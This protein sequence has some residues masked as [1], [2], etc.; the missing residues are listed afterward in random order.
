M[1]KIELEA[2]NGVLNEDDLWKLFSD[3]P[4][5]LAKPS[6]SIL[7][8]SMRS[9]ESGLRTRRGT[10]TFTNTPRCLRRLREPAIVRL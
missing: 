5:N 1:S 6:G 4:D 2:E 9:K 10:I 8:S 7:T 3:H